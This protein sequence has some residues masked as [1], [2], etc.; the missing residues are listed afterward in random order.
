MQENMIT[1]E[2]WIDV[3]GYDGI[4]QISN[5]GKVKSI[6]RVDRGNH[7]VKGRV[8]KEVC[9]GENEHAYV[10]LTDKSG[11]RKKKYIYRLVAEHFVENPN[12]YKSVRHKD[13]DIH[14]VDANNLEW[15]DYMTSKERS[16]IYYQNRDRSKCVRCGKQLDRTGVYCNSC[17]NLRREDGKKSIIFYRSIGICPYC[18]K[19]ILL[20][21]E[22]SCPECRA[23]QA[24]IASRRR[25]GDGYEKIKERIRENGRMKRKERAKNGECTMCGKKLTDTRY[26]MCSACRYKTREKRYTGR[27]VREERVENGFCF[28][29]GAKQLP[30]Y[31]VCEN[32]RNKCISNLSNVDRSYSYWAKDNNLIFIKNKRRNGYGSELFKTH[33]AGT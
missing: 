1:E 5:K 27:S 17:L 16:K 7:F 21:E 20:G 15:F 30:G 22:K 3:K 4:Y 24:E 28:F 2:K 33:K 31:K 29:C 18:K 32:C 6:D 19:E 14:N 26:K 11:N 12:G 9:E 10:S 8:L 25:E 23:K 13:G